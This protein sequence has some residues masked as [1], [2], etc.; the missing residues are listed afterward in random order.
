MQ[1][2]DD[3]ALLRQFTETNS[4]E[5]FSALVKRHI[6]LVYSV[7]LRQVGNSHNAEEIAQAVFIILAKKAAQLR[8]HQALSSWLFQVTRLTANNFVRSE[9]RREH[10]EQEA[11]MQSILNESDN[12]VWLKI[13]P[14]LDNAIAGLREKDRQV[15]LLRF[16]E[17]KSFREIGSVLGASEDAAEKRTKRALDRLRDFFGKRGV[18]STPA[19]LAGMISAHSVQAA[20]AA[21][22]NSI[23]V[24]AIT[25]GVAANSSTLALTKGALKIMAWTKAK[26]ALVTGAAILLVGVPATLTVRNIARTQRTVVDVPSEAAVQPAE[27]AIPLAGDQSAPE[28][29]ATTNVAVAIPEKTAAALIYS[30]AP[31][32]SVILAEAKAATGGTVVPGDRFIQNQYGN[33]FQKLGLTEDQIATFTKIILDQMGQRARVTGAH[34]F[35]VMSGAPGRDEVVAEGRAYQ[36]R[37][38]ASQEAI[39]EAADLQ[40]KALLGTDETF[41]YYQT[42]TAQAPER[43]LVVNDYADG[44]D[45]AGVPP[46]TLDQQ[47]QLVEVLYRARASDD[48]HIQGLRFSEILQGASA[49]LSADQVKV[50]ERYKT[51]VVAAEVTGVRAGRVP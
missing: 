18:S 6:N 20:P 32:L 10:R 36:E 1:P 2:M 40:I 28:P 4:G 50:L 42:Y 38:M 46:L 41:K 33:L 15:V 12:E 24:V 14:L 51:E 7:A 44:L 45:E 3:S 35:Q 49:L 48:W 43:L 47:E 13:A 9:M 27:K 16:Y 37:I 17:R 22:A 31:R 39:N 21:L 30:T 23:T 8:H 26:T 19:I 11:H 29:S 25:K 5:A 34:P